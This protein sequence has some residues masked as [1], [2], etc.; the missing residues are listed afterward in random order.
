MAVIGKSLTM[1]IQLDL[2]LNPSETW[3]RQQIYLNC[4]Y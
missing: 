2:V 3:R 4:H 1:I